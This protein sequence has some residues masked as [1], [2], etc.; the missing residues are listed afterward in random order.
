MLMIAVAQLYGDGGG[1]ANLTILCHS[2]IAE[3]E[4]RNL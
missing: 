2:G 3:G 4:A 1:F